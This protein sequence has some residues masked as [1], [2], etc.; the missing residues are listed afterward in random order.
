MWEILPGSLF[1]NSILSTPRSDVFFGS[2][3][4]QDC[5]ATT[6]KECKIIE[7]VLSIQGLLI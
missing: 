1:H 7:I 3:F 6:P 2:F 5:F 4:Y